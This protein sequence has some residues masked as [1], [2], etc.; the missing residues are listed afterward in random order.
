M[1]RIALYVGS[2]N[3][4]H[5]GHQN[6]YDKACQIFD[7]VIVSIGINP[8]KDNYGI[9]ERVKEIQKFLPNNKITIH[10]ELTVDLI[11]HIQ[12]NN[13]DSSIT[14]IRGLRDGYDLDYETKM[15]RFNQDL[16]PDINVVMILCDREF[17]HLSSSAIRGLNKI[18]KGLG[19]K[20]LP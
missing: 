12:E 9:S 13:P 17:S 18:D 6:I 2:F 20:Y 19:E 14:L 11:K 8:E 7:D 15:L 5:L 10:Q 4:W 16:M 3:P 1:K